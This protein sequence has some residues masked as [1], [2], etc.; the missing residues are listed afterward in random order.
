MG[1]TKSLY[2]DLSCEEVFEMERH[3]DELREADSAAQDAAMEAEAAA[4]AQRVA[5]AF[6]LCAVAA[7]DLVAREHLHA[8]ALAPVADHAAGHRNTG[9]S[10]GA[11][12]SGEQEHAGL[13]KLLD[14]AVALPRQR[15]LALSRC[16]SGVM[17][18]FCACAPPAHHVQLKEFYQPLS[19]FSCRWPIQSSPRNSTNQVIFTHS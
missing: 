14:G 12:R 8:L 10:D 1:L 4:H 3:C 19:R 17:P 18:S 6:T 2:A 16:A 15:G 5:A 11:G 9:A 13:A 7:L